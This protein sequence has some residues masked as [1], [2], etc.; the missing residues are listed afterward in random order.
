MNK[1]IDKII[2]KYR[3]FANYDEQFF[4]FPQNRGC[5]KPRKFQL[6][7]VNKNRI[8]SVSTDIKCP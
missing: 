1:Y 4:K 2:L 5:R 8:L 6:D 7:S 3:K